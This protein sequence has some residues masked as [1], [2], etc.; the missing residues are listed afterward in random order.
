MRKWR[1][2]E[3]MERDRRNGE[4][5]EMEISTFQVQPGTARY[6]AEKTHHV[7]YFL[8]AGSSRI[9]NMILRGHR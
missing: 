5:E 7:L 2:N 1:E 6:N 3:E 9:S 8:Q 4:R